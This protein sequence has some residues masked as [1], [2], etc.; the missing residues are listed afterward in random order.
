MLTRF[1]ENTVWVTMEQIHQGTQKDTASRLFLSSKSMGEA[2]EREGENAM[3]QL[4]SCCLSSMPV[5]VLLWISFLIGA[6]VEH[7]ARAIRTCDQ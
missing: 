5:V 4:R 6:F 7:K 2:R 3:D 1:C